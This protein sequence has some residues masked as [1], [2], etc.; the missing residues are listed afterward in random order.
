MIAEE[1]M[2]EPIR[3]SVRVDRSQ[4]D[5]FELFTEHI[6]EW[7]PT[8]APSTVTSRFPPARS[9]S[10]ARSLTVA[11]SRAYPAAAAATKRSRG[12]RQPSL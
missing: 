4:E 7:W 8:E 11:M 5:A 12:V 6:G 10:G 2:F 1:A 9:L 3:K